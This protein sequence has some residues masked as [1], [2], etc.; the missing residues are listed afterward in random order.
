MPPECTILY[1]IKIVMIQEVTEPLQTVPES[2]SP[3]PSFRTLASLANQSLT[4][5]AHFHDVDSNL[6]DH[7]VGKIFGLSKILTVML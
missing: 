6:S 7:N 1:C 2:S 5:P 4:V 3:S